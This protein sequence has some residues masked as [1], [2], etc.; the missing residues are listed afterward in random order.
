MSSIDFKITGLSDSVKNHLMSITVTD[1]QGVKSDKVRIR[2]DDENYLLK[3]PSLGKEFEVY[4]GYK[5]GGPAL[6]RLGIYQIDEIKFIQSPAAE[7]EVSG[8]A[9]FTY[10]NSMKAPTTKS[11]DNTTLGDMAD[12]IAP[13]HGYTSDVDEDLQAI[14]IDH[15]DQTEESDIHLLTRIADEYD[16]FVKFQDKK[17]IIRSRNKTIGSLEIEKG[18][19]FVIKCNVTKNSRARYKSV[20][21]YWQD[22][23][24]AKRTS[25]TAG[26]EEPEFK[27]KKTFHS[28]L[29]ALDAAKAK[30]QQL[31]RGTKSLD[32]L[33]GPGD[34]NIRAGMK[35]T[36]S[37]FRAEVNGDWIVT[38]VT[39]TLDSSGYTVSL[40]GDWLPAEELVIKLNILFDTGKDVVAQKYYS[41]IEDLAT[42]LKGRDPETTTV[43]LQGHTDSRN[44]EAY[45]LDL[46]S[47]RANAVREILIQNYGVNSSQVTAVGYGETQLLI[48]PET[49]SDDYAQNRRVVAVLSGE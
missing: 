4:L 19:P 46:S 42:T 8:S 47:R 18:G 31:K 21:A 20:R 38:S 28:K 5:H 2:F 6:A 39:H 15:I 43:E 40:K 25:E 32:N 44:S 17:L 37:G 1:E 16:S 24:K 10:N 41:I 9:L 36:L 33:T 11:W 45:N 34:P 48:S 3:A 23:D 14:T 30:L 13:K 29:N 22:G 35:L 12:A 7:I 26:E 49:T 27:I